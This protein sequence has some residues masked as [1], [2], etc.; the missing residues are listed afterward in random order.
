MTMKSVGKAFLIL[1][2]FTS[3][4]KTLEKLQERRRSLRL[5]EDAERIVAE[6][7]QKEHLGACI[8]RALEH[9]D[10]AENGPRASDST[11]NTLHRDSIFLFEGHLTVGLEPRPPAWLVAQNLL[12]TLA[13]TQEQVSAVESSQS[14]GESNRKNNF[15]LD[16]TSA[17]LEELVKTM[18]EIS[19]LQDIHSVIEASLQEIGARPKKPPPTS[20]EM[21]ARLPV[22]TVT[23]EIWVKLGRETE[24]ALCMENLVIDDKMQSCL[25][26]IYFQWLD[27]Y[28]SCPIC[29][30]ELQT[31]N[32]AYESWK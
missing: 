1:W 12:T 8:A 9:L 15:D 32:H 6:S 5:F 25:A 24:C 2:N 17:M 14:H 4:S 3:L 26:R 29:R 30:H 23:P 11:P 10:E 31:E 21:V 22:I 13:T 18:Q 19:G 28:N 7:S 20:K 27:E 16:A